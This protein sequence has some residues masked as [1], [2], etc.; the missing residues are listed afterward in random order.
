MVVDFLMQEEQLTCHHDVIVTILF[1][2]EN[3]VEDDFLLT[4]TYMHF[5]F[6][7]AFPEI[8]CG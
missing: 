6:T 8:D 4:R 2:E 3:K 1:K 5:T 7:L